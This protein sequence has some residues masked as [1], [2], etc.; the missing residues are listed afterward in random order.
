MTKEK[1]NSM[2]LFNEVLAAK[3]QLENVIA[4]TPLTQNLN[5]SDEFK[6]TVL[7]KREDYKLSGLIK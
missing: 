4:A 1:A 5:L 2:N 3:K 6:S 7:L